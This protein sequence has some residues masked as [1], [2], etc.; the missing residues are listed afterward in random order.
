MEK[1][2]VIVVSSP[3]TLGVKEIVEVVNDPRVWMVVGGT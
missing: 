3:E 2:A 1:A